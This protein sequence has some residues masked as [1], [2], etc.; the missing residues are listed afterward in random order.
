[1]AG[2]WSPGLPASA[3]APPSPWRSRYAPEAVSYT[4]LDVYKRQAMTFAAYAVPGPWERLVAAAAV[5]A[6]VTVNLS[7]I[8]I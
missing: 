3:P 5:V 6:L 1:M 8:H 4:H 7:L 2:I